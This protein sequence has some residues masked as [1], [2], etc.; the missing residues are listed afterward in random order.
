MRLMRKRRLLL[1]AAALTTAMGACKPNR[2]YANT[3]RPSYPDAPTDAGVGDASP[4]DA[5][6]ASSTAEPPR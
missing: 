2:V 4:S 3:K 6:E 5:G 1:A